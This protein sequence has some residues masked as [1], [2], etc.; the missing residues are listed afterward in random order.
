MKGTDYL[1]ADYPVALDEH[2]CILYCLD[3]A[4][5]QLLK[6]E[7]EVVHL[8]MKDIEKSVI[9]IQKMQMKK[10]EVENIYLLIQRLKTIGI[11][12]EIIT[13]RFGGLYE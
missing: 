3:E 1:K 6:G 11:E 4:K 8:L 12:A 5:E 10:K 9:T 7:I 13:K 2:R